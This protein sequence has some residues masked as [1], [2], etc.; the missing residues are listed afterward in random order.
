M[1]NDRQASRSPEDSQALLVLQS[2]GL[3]LR[4]LYLPHQQRTA[5]ATLRSS[6]SWRHIPCKTLSVFRVEPACVSG[7][8]S[9]SVFRV[10]ATSLVDDISPLLWFINCR[11][12]LQMSLLHQEKEYTSKSRHENKSTVS[13]LP[14]NLTS[15]LIPLTLTKGA[16]L[17]PAKELRKQNSIGRRRSHQDCSEIHASLVKEL[18]IFTTQTSELRKLCSTV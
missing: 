9:P 12:F 2:P 6:G 10:W 5:V 1:K 14:Q 13:I 7:S 18:S 4:S 16:S 8:K 3:P 11:H 15:S 17:I